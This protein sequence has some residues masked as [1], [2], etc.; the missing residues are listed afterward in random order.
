M[1]STGFG[2]LYDDLYGFAPSGGTSMG[3]AVAPGARTTGVGS[4]ASVQEAADL[5]KRDTEGRAT[6]LQ[7][8]PRLTQAMDFFG[9]VMDGG[10]MPYTQGAK[11]AMLSKQAGMNAAAQ[12]AQ[13]HALQ[14]ASAA[15]GGSVYD[16]SYQA[17]AAELNAGRQTANA[18]AAG[19]IDARAAGANFDARM[20]GA[21]Q[22]VGARSGQN[23]QINAMKSLAAEHA[24]RTSAMVPS[25]VGGITTMPRTSVGSTAG[26][27]GGPWSSDSGFKMDMDSDP[28]F[29]PRMKA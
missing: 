28:F 23:A 11:S 25:T 14:E 24:S 17:K 18:N 21:G 22:L 19:D 4:P 13:M 5:I 1:G 10:V 8:D 2:G 6:E 9:K 15:N 16:P 20:A 26:G 27:G 3:T 12:A 29:N 7:K